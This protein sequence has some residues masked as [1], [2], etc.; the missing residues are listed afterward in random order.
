MISVIV[1]VYDQVASGG[2]LLSALKEQQCRDRFE[3]LVCDDGS[4]CDM[5]G[6]VREASR[7]GALEVRYIWQPHRGFRAGRSRNNGIRAAQGD[8]LVFV[9]GD[10]LVEKDFVARHAA[11]H[12]R[13][14]RLIV[15][16]IKRIPGC[17]NGTR[18]SALEYARA[19]RN[20]DAFL[21]S[22]AMWVGSAYPWMSCLSGNM[23][24]PRGPEVHFDEQF[25]GWGGEDRELAYRLSAC[26]GYDVVFDP[27]AIAY[28]P[29]TT[30]GAHVWT[31]SKRIAAYLRNRL[32]FRSLYPDADLSPVFDS[33]RHLAVDP[34][35]D[36]WR[37]A[38]TARSP[39]AVLHEAEQWLH[40]H[41]LAAE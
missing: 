3:V 15:G 12:A 19:Y 22:Q 33:I 13:P 32:H 24:M 35:T 8:L 18:A 36:T 39:D 1:T 20:A 6:V 37:V 5:V 21:D 38:T 17:P 7:D 10:M 2:W 4:S 14:G 28:H 9:D 26:H 16:P 41:D 30:T 27:S 29:G 23:S 11:A 31:D 25:V 40:T 34:S